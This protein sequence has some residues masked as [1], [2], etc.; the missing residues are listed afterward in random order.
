MKTTFDIPEPLLREVQALARERKSTTKSL[1]EEA[2]RALVDRSEATAR[3]TLPDRAVGG[4]G[5]A[6]EFQG[7]SWEA[8]RDA[9]Y[10]PRL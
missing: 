5:L 10:G 2:L 6:P 1:V 3:Y 7:M 8:V 4:D 9:A